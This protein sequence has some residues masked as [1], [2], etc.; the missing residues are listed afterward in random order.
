MNGHVKKSLDAGAAGCIGKPYRTN[1]L[2]RKVR[3]ILD[4]GR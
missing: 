2:F 3:E 4:E 1:V